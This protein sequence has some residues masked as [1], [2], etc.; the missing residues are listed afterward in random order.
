[1]VL[2]QQWLLPLLGS[3]LSPGG[4]SSTFCNLS[5]SVISSRNRLI[6]SFCLAI[7]PNRSSY[8][9]FP[10]AMFGLVIV[11]LLHTSRCSWSSFGGGSCRLRFQHFSG[12]S[13][14]PPYRLLKFA[15]NDHAV[16]VR[17][18]NRSDVS[19]FEKM[20]LFR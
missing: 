4:L 5:L 1:M 3:R 11:T 14:L 20:G 7:S 8:V 19:S 16:R 9:T 17:R 12:H 18:A 2:L 15:L 13:T 6:T 10:S